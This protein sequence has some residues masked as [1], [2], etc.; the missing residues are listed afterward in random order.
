MVRPGFPPL[1]DSPAS[2][3]ITDAQ[4][5][6]FGNA[7]YKTFLTWLEAYGIA[8]INRTLETSSFDR[9]DNKYWCNWKPTCGT[10]SEHT[11]SEIDRF[12]KLVDEVELN[13]GLTLIPFGMW[14]QKHGF[15]RDFFD[16]QIQAVMSILFVT[17]TG[18]WHQPTSAVINYFRKTGWVY[19]RPQDRPVVWN[20]EGGS[21]TFYQAMT[22][23]IGADNIHASTP[24]ATV[25][26]A[27][28]GSFAVYTGDRDGT[29]EL[30]GH[31]G[32]VIMATPA[33]EALKA[34][35]SG[36]RGIMMSWLLG[37]MQFTAAEVLLH[38]DQSFLPSEES[39][40]RS[41]YNVRWT[42]DG[43]DWRTNLEMT[44]LIQRVFGYADSQPE[45]LLTVNN[46]SSVAGEI[47]KYFVWEHHTVDLWFL[48]LVRAYLPA[49][50]GAG[51]IFYAGDWTWTIGHEDAMIA[52]VRAACAAG[53]RMEAD[54]AVATPIESAAYATLIKDHCG[55]EAERDDPT[56]G[57]TSV[58]EV[59]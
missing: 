29:P 6:I 26:S 27:S 17:K 12:M 58:N 40:A 19:L 4:G 51:R 8:H 31:F 48:V 15:D 3:I 22:S 50:N 33:N 37:Q 56:T 46:K 54:P 47:Y 7:G 45:L 41:L 2:P 38:T 14:L 10:V 28:N 13:F 55:P 44:G 5:F 9:A 59:E 39:G 49:I 43:R 35:H 53:I 57:A 1:S 20:V 11:V 32:D 42:E 34:V 30:F 36:D 25:K 52:G 16:D 24:V 18:T 21:K 23:R